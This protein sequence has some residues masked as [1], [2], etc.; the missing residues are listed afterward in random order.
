V[1]NFSSFLLEKVNATDYHG[2]VAA[3][4]LRKFLRSKRARHG[5][6]I[7]QA[8]TNGTSRADALAN[9]P[10]ALHATISILVE[11]NL[12]IPNPGKLSGKH[13]ALIALP[14]AVVDARAEL[15]MAFRAAGIRKAEL[16]RRMGIHKQQGER[17]LGCGV[18]WALII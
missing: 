14:S 1:T 16:A 11:K 6:K 17:L 15:Y 7:P 18:I 8:H 9:A 10:D 12:D 2:T 3:R 4:E 5:N 13:T